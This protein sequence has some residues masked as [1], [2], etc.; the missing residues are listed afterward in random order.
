MPIRFREDVSRILRSDPA[1]R[2]VWEVILCYPGLH[3]LQSHRLAHWLWNRRQFCLAR[4]VSHLARWVTGIEIHPGAKVSRRVFIDHGLGVVIGETAIIGEDVTIYQGATL[5][6]T[7]LTRGAKRHPTLED[8]VVIG[9]GAK[10]LG[11][12]TIGA[13]ARVGSNSVV[14][15]SVPPG[16]TAVGIPARII[17]PGARPERTGDAMSSSAVELIQGKDIVLL[18]ELHSMREQIAICEERIQ[19]MLNALELP[20]GRRWPAGSVVVALAQSGG[21]PED[22]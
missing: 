6:G 16:A 3:A 19:A 5:G 9:A 4:M 22:V 12:I 7:S 21:R 15:E 20:A 18:K 13:G 11:D 14:L 8:G 10:I 17:V 2:S 1:A